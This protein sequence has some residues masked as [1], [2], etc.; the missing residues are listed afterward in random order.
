VEIDRIVPASGNLFAARR[1][2]WLGTALAGQQVTL[3]LDHTSLNVFR[4]GELLKTHPVNLEAKDLAR[5]RVTVA[6][7]P[8]P[9]PPPLCRRAGCPP[10]P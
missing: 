6:G 1:Q 3:R 8:G 4:D 2:I 5:L 10:A 7:L 9:R